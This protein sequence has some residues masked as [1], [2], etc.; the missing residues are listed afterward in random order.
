MADGF[1]VAEWLR[2]NDS[3]T[4]KCLRETEVTWSDVGQENG[5]FFHKINHGPVIW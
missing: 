4:Y 5:N 2:E 1:Q 3:D